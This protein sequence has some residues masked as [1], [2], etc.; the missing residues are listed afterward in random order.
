MLFKKKK[1]TK[2]VTIDKPRK[3]TYAQLD[4]QIHYDNPWKEK[5]KINQ[6]DNK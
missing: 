2:K 5:T 6:K 1:K 3:S 4:S